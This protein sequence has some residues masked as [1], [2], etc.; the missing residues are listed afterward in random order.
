V[1]ARAHHLVGLWGQA[2][3]LLEVPA[4]AVRAGQEIG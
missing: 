4:Q 2:E 3:P 1:L